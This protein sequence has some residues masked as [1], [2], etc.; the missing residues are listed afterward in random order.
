MSIKVGKSK[1][2]VMSKYL[3]FEIMSYVFRDFQI[4]EL[5]SRMGKTCKD[6]VSKNMDLLDNICQ[7]KG[8]E[9]KCPTNLNYVDAVLFTKV[10]LLRMK[11]EFQIT[12]NILDLLY[13]EKLNPQ[14]YLIE[15]LVYQ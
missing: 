15:S 14:K 12:D 9:F 5:L 10:K 2:L 8:Q 1:K 6:I 4:V 11:G 7:R 3:L 13:L